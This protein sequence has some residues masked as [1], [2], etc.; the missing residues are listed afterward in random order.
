MRTRFLSLVAAAA[1][2]LGPAL[3]APV[4]AHAEP[5]GAS[6]YAAPRLE[7]ASNFRDLG[8]YPAAGG[9]TVRT[10][11][12]FRSNKLSNLTEADKQKLTDTGVTLAVDLRN[13]SERD[14]APDSL[15][16]GVRYQVADMI[17]LDHGLWF[18][19]FVP[20]TLGRAL[21]DAYTTDSSNVGQ[22]IGY[23]FMVSFVGADAAFRDTLIAIAHNPGGTVFHCS[24]GKDRTGWTAATLLSILGVP[25]ADIEADFLKSNDYLGRHAVDLSW[26]RAAFDQAE[27][28][29]GSMD[30]YVRKGLRLDAATVHT[31]RDRL[32][33]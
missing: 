18:H 6:T 27:R 9:K 13:A 11:I 15:P 20:I 31:L 25:R 1:V 30:G 33:T 23:P 19:E 7:G 4:S 17:T 22:S 5:G 3:V 16:A 28:L 2:A 10:G 29:Y 12:A 21:I 26:L 14:E 24:A 8:G 32:L